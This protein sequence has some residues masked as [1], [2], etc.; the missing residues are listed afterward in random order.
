[1]LVFLILFA[2]GAIVAFAAVTRFQKTEEGSRQ[3][4]IYG[5]STLAGVVFVVVGV[6]G[7]IVTI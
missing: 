2:I 7:F 5:Y 4:D 6:I 3:E 1:M